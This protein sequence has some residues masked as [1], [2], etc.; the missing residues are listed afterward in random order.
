[1]QFGIAEGNSTQREVGAAVQHGVLFNL[2]YIHFQQNYTPWA[3]SVS[4]LTDK[5]R[6]N[7]VQ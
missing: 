2:I 1:M 4:S 7:I 3:R 6:Y 5:I